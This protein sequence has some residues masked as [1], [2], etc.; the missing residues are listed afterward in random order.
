[1]DT[2]LQDENA[3]DF[4]LE[5]DNHIHGENIEEEEEDAEDHDL[6]T[7]NDNIALKTMHLSGIDQ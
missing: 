1:M 7:E 2:S 3:F 4:D 6:Q 5:A